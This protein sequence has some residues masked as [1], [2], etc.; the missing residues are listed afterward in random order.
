MRNK[1]T[2]EKLAEMKRRWEA[3]W[4]PTSKKP[5]VRETPGGGYLID[6]DGNICNQMPNSAW[7]IL[8]GATLIFSACVYA[9]T[10]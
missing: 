4:T 10:V 6:E 3:Q 9:V 8:A 1:Y 2:P 5:P 7:V